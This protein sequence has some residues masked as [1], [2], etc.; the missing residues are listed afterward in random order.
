[1]KIN[2]VI[3]SKDGTNFQLCAAI[4]EQGQYV[5]VI[6]DQSNPTWEI[7]LA[8]QIDHWL[9]RTEQEVKIIAKSL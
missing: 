7:N 5:S 4:N 8:R 3:I 6:V 9:T 2:N 1:M